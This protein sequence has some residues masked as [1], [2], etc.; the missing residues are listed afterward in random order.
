MEYEF[1]VM[2]RGSN[3]Q[4]KSLVISL[5]GSSGPSKHSS[6]LMV[7]VGLVPALWIIARQQ[8]AALL[9]A[10]HQCWLP[11]ITFVGWDDLPRSSRYL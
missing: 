3:S 1:T 6:Y 5:L 4:P 7:S 2:E 9:L 8:Q 10:G 11:Q